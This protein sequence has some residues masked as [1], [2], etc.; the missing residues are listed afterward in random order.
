MDSGNVSKLCLHGHTLGLNT[1]K[2]HEGAT[3]KLYDCVGTGKLVGQYGSSVPTIQINKGTL[4]LYGGTIQDLDGYAVE[5]NG[6]NIICFVG[7]IEGVTSHV[8]GNYT[9]DKNSII[10]KLTDTLLS[11]RKKAVD[12]NTQVPQTGDNSH[13]I[14]WSLLFITSLSFTF[15]LRKKH[16]LR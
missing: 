7:D 6:G 8:N 16:V 5:N 12:S 2:I 9:I 11:V 14:L 10:V 1:V 13:I 15:M 4:E 3:L